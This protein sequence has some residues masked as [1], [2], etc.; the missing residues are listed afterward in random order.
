[1]EYWTS[2]HLVGIIVAGATA[3]ELGHV[4]PQE[5]LSS[6]ETGANDGKVDLNYPVTSMSVSRIPTADIRI[7]VEAVHTYHHTL[8]PTRSHVMSELLTSATVRLAL[9]IL[10]TSTLEIQ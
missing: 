4:F 7:K 3:D 1:M 5:W 6:W 10:T 2:I 8:A 9:T